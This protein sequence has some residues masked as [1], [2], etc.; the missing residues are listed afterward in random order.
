MFQSGEAV[1]RALFDRWNE[2]DADGIAALFAEDADFVTV[3]GFRWRSRK[4]IRKTHGHGFR[5]IFQ[6]ATVEISELAVR[7]LTPEFH[8]VHTVSTL[9]GQSGLGSSK[10]AVTVR[11]RNRQLPEHRPGRW[12]NRVAICIFKT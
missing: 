4:A 1:A 8:I 3:V 12:H 11:L 5:R 9:G 10:A 2:G 6:N 7:A